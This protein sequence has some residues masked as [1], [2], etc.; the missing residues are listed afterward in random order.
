MAN[1]SDR[2]ST[3]VVD[4][5]YLAYV[6]ALA[7]DDGEFAEFIAEYTAPSDAA[8]TAS[9]DIRKPL[10]T[11]LRNPVRKSFPRAA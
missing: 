8:V 7:V 10:I 9:G 2:D 6:R 5:M 1:S 11:T 3:E 4:D